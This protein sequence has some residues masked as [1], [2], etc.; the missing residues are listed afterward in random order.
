M[1]TSVHITSDNVSSHL[2][3]LNPDDR[4]QFFTTLATSDMVERVYAFSP[5]ATITTANL[6]DPLYN[7]L[8]PILFTE[9][10]Q[11]GLVRVVGE[12]IHDDYIF[13]YHPGRIDR[14]GLVDLVQ[15]SGVIPHLS[16]FISSYILGHTPHN[17]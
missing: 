10:D 3:S 17:E 1:F 2:S 15:Q 11:P 12:L 14:E 8:I 7:G 4:I 5:N 9:P 13:Q 16:H 6:Q